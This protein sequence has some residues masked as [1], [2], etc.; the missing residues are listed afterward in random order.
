MSVA[1][2]ERETPSPKKPVP[3]PAYAR[4]LYTKGVPREKITAWRAI[5]RKDVERAKLVPGAV[6]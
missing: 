1:G 5:A 2:L 4:E 3:A 6:L